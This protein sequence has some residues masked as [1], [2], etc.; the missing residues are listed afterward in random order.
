MSIFEALEIFLIEQQIRGNS[1]K[2]VSYYRNCV[3]PFAAYFQDGFAVSDL[4]IKGIKDYALFLR[5]RG[6]TDNS[7]KTY[8]KGIKA[9]LSWLYEEKYI[10]V[11]LSSQWKLPK[12]QRKTIDVLTDTE[13]HQLFKCFD[14]SDYIGLRNFCMCALMLDSGLRRSEVVALSVDDLHLI[15][16]YIIVNGKGNKQRFVPVGFHCRKYLLRYVA[17]RPCSVRYKALFLTRKLTPITASTI[18]R[19]SK[20]LKKECLTP[21]FRPHLLRHTF[22]TR[23]LENGGNIYALQQIL[24]HTSLDMVKKYVHLTTRKNLVN[25]SNYS[26]MDNLR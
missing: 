1:D 16:G 6:I 3:K 8:T 22:A 14:T 9:F 13:I 25:F 26:P 7:V 17:L 18:E 24:G 20:K 15:E 5:R 4:T 11:D 2:T 21:R 23:Y 19:L 10:T 12:A